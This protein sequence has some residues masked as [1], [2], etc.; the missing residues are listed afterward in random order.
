MKLQRPFTSH[1]NDSEY[2][3]YQK[4]VF[5]VP[6][7]FRIRYNLNRTEYKNKEVVN[8][9]KNMSFLRD[10]ALYNSGNEC[11]R[12]YHIWS[13]LVLLAATAGRRVSCR[14]GYFDILSNLI[15]HGFL[16]KHILDNFTIKGLNLQQ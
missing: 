4:L 7:T 2:Y 12:N 3:E 6:I 5:G 16:H 1:D 9:P 10:Y 13:A 11:S 15:L 8:I 14:W